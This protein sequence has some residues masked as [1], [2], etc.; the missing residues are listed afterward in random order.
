LVLQ[1][2]HPIFNLKSSVDIAQSSKLLLL[3]QELFP[4]PGAHTNNI[5]VLFNFGLLSS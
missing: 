3:I 1:E 5:K 2:Y 4:T